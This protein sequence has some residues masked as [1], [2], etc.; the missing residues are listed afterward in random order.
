MFQMKNMSKLNNFQK[1]Y[2]LDA[3]EKWFYNFILTNLNLKCFLINEFYFPIL[4]IINDIIY[5]RKT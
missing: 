4:F 1:V 5:I 3:N 2:C